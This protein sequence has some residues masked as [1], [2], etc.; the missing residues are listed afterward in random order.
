MRGGHLANVA[1]L[2]SMK[3][4]EGDGRSTPIPVSSPGSL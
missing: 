3:G 1:Q 4:E 2:V